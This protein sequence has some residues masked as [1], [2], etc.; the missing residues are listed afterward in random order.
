MNCFT[1]EKMKEG[2]NVFNIGDI[3]HTFYIIIKGTCSVLIRNTKIK[4]WY[5]DYKHY[6]DLL[7]WKKKEFDPKCEQ[8]KETHME[9]YNVVKKKISF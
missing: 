5:S 1:L 9:N 7:S 6:K 2:Q 4:E 3:G 8:I